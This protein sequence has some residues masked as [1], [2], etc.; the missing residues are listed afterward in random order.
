[1][2][3][4]GCSLD[5]KLRNRLGA[6]SAPRRSYGIYN[7]PGLGSGFDINPPTLSFDQPFEPPPGASLQTADILKS[8]SGDSGSDFF[9]FDFDAG[10]V[11]GGAGKAV[12]G[13]LPALVGLFGG[14]LGG[15]T[16]TQIAKAQ[17]KAQQSL[18][19]AQERMNQARIDA[20]LE[21][22]RLSARAQE[23]KDAAQ[24][25]VLRVQQQVFAQKSANEQAVLAAQV[26]AAEINARNAKAGKL[27]TAAWAIP[28]AVVGAGAIGLTIWA[29]RRK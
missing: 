12:A 4:S 18:V 21:M 26:R 19:S 5:Q 23:A 29:V 17:T 7:A 24:G 22:A 20:G 6:G 11:L 15:K 28:A 16:Q 10:D 13:A 2:L 25:E 14:L 8:F 27:P 3:L 1:M 9:K